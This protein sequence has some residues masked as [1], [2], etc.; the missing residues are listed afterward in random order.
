MTTYFPKSPLADTG[1]WENWPHADIRELS[2]SSNST[3]LIKLPNPLEI[4]I[5]YIQSFL[6]AMIT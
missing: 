6:I 2:Q 1:I 5:I 3:E 4:C